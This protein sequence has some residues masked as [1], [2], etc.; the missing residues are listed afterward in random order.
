LST[1]RTA[2]LLH[3]A[4]GKTVGFAGAWI[5]PKF[6]PSS[7]QNEKNGLIHGPMIRYTRV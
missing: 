1:G 6:P 4:E 7:P 2:L 3:S 5:S